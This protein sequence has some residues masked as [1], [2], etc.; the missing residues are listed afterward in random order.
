MEKKIYQERYDQFIDIVAE[1]ILSYHAQS[2]QLTQ[3]SNID[4]GTDTEEGVP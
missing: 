3:D 2:N 1:L 4:Q